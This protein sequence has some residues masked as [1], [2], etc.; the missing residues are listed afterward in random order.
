MFHDSRGFEAGAVDEL[1]LVKGF[2]ES[3][4]KE[5]ELDQQLHAIWFTFLLYSLSTT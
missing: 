5:K 3:R 4:L 2:I 1:D